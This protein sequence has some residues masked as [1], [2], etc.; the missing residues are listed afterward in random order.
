MYIQVGGAE[1][2]HKTYFGIL[3]QHFL[4]SSNSKLNKAKPYP[5][6]VPVCLSL[7]SSS[8]HLPSRVAPQ[9]GNPKYP[10]LSPGGSRSPAQ[11]LLSWSLLRSSISDLQQASLLS[12]GAQLLPRRAPAGGKPTCRSGTTSSAEQQAACR[13]CL[14]SR[15]F[16]YSKVEY[17]K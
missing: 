5:H 3:G 15:W 2:I 8:C 16:F 1:K 14:A 11:L 13:I 6:L 4:L 10:I 12:A 7:G 17:V 9:P